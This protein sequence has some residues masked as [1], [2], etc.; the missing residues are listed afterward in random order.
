[1]SESASSE[2][3]TKGRRLQMVLEQCEELF[4]TYG[5]K[6]VSMDEVVHRVG[7]SKKTLYQLVPN[8]T[9]LIEAFVERMLAQRL[10]EI[11]E[12]LN[13]NH[14]VLSATAKL[15]S[16]LQGQTWKISAAMTMDLQRHWPHLHDRI[17]VTRR[18][19]IRS[20][21]EQLAAKDENYLRPELHRGVL[22]HMIE[23]MIMQTVTP[24][25]LVDLNLSVHEAIHTVLEA[26]LG[27][28]LNE[29][30]RRR[31]ERAREDP[32]SQ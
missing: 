7:M 9:A 32:A 12:V 18:T 2:E 4:F 8:K 14:D 31:L 11:E 19:S 24:K 15:L 3:D 16:L 5:F 29:D 10:R 21:I 28:I 30:G 13:A 22:M 27:G 25:L 6:R 20:Y 1:M 23:A 17:E 26:M